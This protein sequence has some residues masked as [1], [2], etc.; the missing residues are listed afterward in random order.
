MAKKAQFPK[1]LFVY[2]ENEGTQDE[3]LMACKTE[4]ECANLN[5]TRL[6]GVYE[7]KEVGKILVRVVQVAA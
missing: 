6:V 3:F 1:K 5:E 2:V 7:L 4:R